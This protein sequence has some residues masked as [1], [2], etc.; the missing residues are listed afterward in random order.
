MQARLV[1]MLI[2]PTK[3][4]RLLDGEVKVPANEDAYTLAH[5]LAEAGLGHVLDIVPNHMGLGSGNGLWLDLLENGPSAHAAKFFD[6][7][8]HPVKEELSDKVDRE[9]QSSDGEY[10]GRVIRERYITPASVC[11]VL[12]GNNTAKSGW[13]AWEIGE[14]LKQKMGKIFIQ[15]MRRRGPCRLFVRSSSCSMT[16]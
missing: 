3:R 1:S 5:L 2:S 14:C 11:V 15:S 16:N 12:I 9:A 13:V 4:N 8:W 6:V 7:E 10:V